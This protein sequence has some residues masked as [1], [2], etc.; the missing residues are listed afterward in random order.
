MRTF[1]FWSNRT[2]SFWDYILISKDYLENNLIISLSPAFA[3]A[4]SRRQA[5]RGRIILA[6]FHGLR[7]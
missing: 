4:A 7:W 2:L 5:S 1:L 6:N 3:E